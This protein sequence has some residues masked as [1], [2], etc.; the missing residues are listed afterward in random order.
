MRR[1]E[2]LFGLNLERTYD[3]VAK[4]K[5]FLEYFCKGGAPKKPCSVFHMLVAALIVVLAVSI[6]DGYE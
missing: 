2:G 5:P 3:S 6:T 1:L 4:L